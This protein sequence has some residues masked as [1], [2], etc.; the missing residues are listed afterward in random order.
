MARTV[1]AT[2]GQLAVVSGPAFRPFVTEVLPLVI[3]AIQDAATPDK[4]LVAVKALGQ[5]RPHNGPAQ[6]PHA[7]AWCCSGTWGRGHQEGRTWCDV[8]CAWGTAMPDR[9]LVAVKALGPG[10]LPW[11][12]LGPPS[13]HAALV[14][15]WQ[16]E[17][18]W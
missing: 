11:F 8:A 12:E 2:I 14:L 6:L 17:V 15:E 4:R 9:R 18:W 16:E 5:V 7:V 3:E 13:L 10:E 1:L